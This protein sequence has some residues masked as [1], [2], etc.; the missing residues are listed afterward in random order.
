MR[1]TPG[2]LRSRRRCDRISGHVAPYPPF[3]SLGSHALGHFV[4]LPLAEFLEK[5][6]FGLRFGRLV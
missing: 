4:F 2:R 3:F 1:L 6:Q 5:G